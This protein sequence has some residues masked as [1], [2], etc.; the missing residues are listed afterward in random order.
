MAQEG[1]QQNFSHG[2][3]V[4]TVLNRDLANEMNTM[5]MYMA[6]SLLVRGTDS[7]DVK[8]VMTEFVQQDFKHA[9]RLA[10]RIVD[11]DG[12]PELMPTDLQ[13]NASID[14]KQSRDINRV[15]LLKDALEHELQAVIEYKNQIQNIGFT[16]PATRLL[17]EEILTD[18]EHQAEEIRHLLGV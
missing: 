9:Q 12:V 8:G 11:L 2:Q 6:D 14:A 16:D 15:P 4:L 5:L 7:H 3:D 13:N 18:K 1:S 10:S 17:L